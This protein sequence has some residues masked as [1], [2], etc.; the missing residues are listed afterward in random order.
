MADPYDLDFIAVPKEDDRPFLTR[1]SDYLKS[2]GWQDPAPGQRGTFVPSRINDQGKAELAVPGIIQQPAE[3]LQSLMTAPLSDLARMRDPD[4]TRTLAEQSFDV[5]SM[6]P[7]AGV[8]AGRTTAS[9]A[10]TTYRQGRDLGTMYGPADYQYSRAPIQEGEWK[11]KSMYGQQLLP[12]EIRPGDLKRAGEATA[13]AGVRVLRD[14]EYIPEFKNIGQD[15]ARDIRRIDGGAVYSNAD[16]PTTA[17]ILAAINQN[18]LSNFDRASTHPRDLGADGRNVLGSPKATHTPSIDNEAFGWWRDVGNDVIDARTGESVY[19]WDTANNFNAI[20]G[21]KAPRAAIEGFNE[22]DAYTLNKGMM[23]FMEAEAPRRAFLNSN[24]DDVNTAV[25]L[26]AMQGIDQPMPPARLPQQMM[27]RGSIGDQR[28]DIQARELQWQMPRDRGGEVNAPAAPANANQAS[29]VAQM[30]GDLDAFEQMVGAGLPP[31]RQNLAPDTPGATPLNDW[32]TPRDAINASMPVLKDLASRY[33][34]S[35]MSSEGIAA[36]MGNLAYPPPADTHRMINMVAD[37]IRRADPPKTPYGFGYQ[38]TD[39]PT[40][41]Q[42]MSGADGDT[43]VVG[44]KATADDVEKALRSKVGPDGRWL[45]SN[46]DPT[47]SAILAL[48]TAQQGGQQPATESQGSSYGM[49]DLF[50]AVL[51]VSPASALDYRKDDRESGNVVDKRGAPLGPPDKS[52]WE[53]LMTDGRVA[54][55][56]REIR[57]AKKWNGVPDEE[58]KKMRDKD[59][60]DLG[61]MI[62]GKYG[63]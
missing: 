39:R 40:G 15:P 48:L 1:L 29:S 41:V 24:P 45:F 49:S 32:K 7:A 50:N 33:G 42:W 53:Y 21:G 12:L 18:T 23:D 27:E 61:K 2:G 28:P 55:T 44:T 26:A 37:G 3:S 34:A 10:P 47:T 30:T 54:T 6:L 17:A 16:D 31:Q 58:K 20:Q 5:A 22:H 36:R 60:E 13:G 62:G 63:Q 9:S 56:L 38:I 19:D 11:R 59:Y 57:D 43:L 8:A 4:I 35:L 14:G 51:G 25:I 52:L 46:S